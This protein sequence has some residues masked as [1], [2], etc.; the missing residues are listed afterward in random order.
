MV[1]HFKIWGKTKYNL[2]CPLLCLEL[3]RYFTPKI[4]HTNIS[5]CLNLQSLHPVKIVIPIYANSQNYS[6]RLCH[7]QNSAT[8][9]EN[10]IFVLLAKI[11]AKQRWVL[12]GGF[13]FFFQTYLSYL[14]CLIKILIWRCREKLAKCSLCK[15]NEFHRPDN[16]KG[17]TNLCSIIFFINQREELMAVPQDSNK[18]KDLLLN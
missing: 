4:Y 11:S 5:E 14:R 2:E 1:S 16:W 8:G 3:L 10:V 7:L 18:N 15:I 13:F 17:L 9:D 12:F 6:V